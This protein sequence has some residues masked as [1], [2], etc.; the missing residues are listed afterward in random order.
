MFPALALL[1]SLTACSDYDLHRP[2]GKQDGGEPQ[3]TGTPP[4]PTE[5]PDILVTPTSLYFGGIPKGCDSPAQQVTIENV[6]LGDLVVDEISVEGEGTS[7][8]AVSGVV[9]PATL[10]AGESVTADVVFSP[11]AWVSYAPEI[12]ISSNDP[13]ESVVDVA[14]DGYGAED[15][16]YEESFEQDYHEMLD[17]VWVIDNSGSMSDDLRT[18]SNNF[19]SFIE[20][21]TE[22]TTDWQIAVITTD[23][24]DPSDSGRIQGPIITPDMSD[25]IGEFISQVDQGSGGSASEQGFAATMAAL[26]EPLLSGYNAGIMRD[27]A[28]LAVVVISDEDDSS[29]TSASAFHSFLEGLKPDP[30]WTTFSAICED[31]LISCYKYGEAADLSGGIVG[32]I[33]S[34]DYMT[35]LDD[36]SRT[37]AGLTVSFDLTYEPSDLSRT[38][39][40]VGTTT[41]PQD[42]TNGWSYDSLDNAIVFH[43]SA[44]PEPGETGTVRYPIATECGD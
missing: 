4:E 21:F 29:T 38:E 25:P 28:A 11:N 43:G 35:V 40:R 34:T 44:I 7:A 14:L 31:F 20:V 12:R 10:A 1:V 6:G 18:V 39:V 30:D 41:I 5:D 37:S 15:S 13:D 22:L 33:A 17:V 24:D 42:T 9:T 8:F 27:D 16:V 19:A 23:M 2:D 36:I 26:S 3:D 32:D